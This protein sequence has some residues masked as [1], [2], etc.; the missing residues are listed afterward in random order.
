MKGFEEKCEDKKLKINSKIKISQKR[1]F[2]NAGTKKGLKSQYCRLN[3]IPV[4]II[5]YGVKLQLS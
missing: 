1:K 2:Q 4:N 5:L 3:F